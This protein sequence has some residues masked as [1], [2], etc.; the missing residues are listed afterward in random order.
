MT[1]QQSNQGQVINF[2]K[3]KSKKPRKTGVNQNRGG[4][5]RNINGKAYVDF[6]YLG[7]RVRENS[8]LAWNTQNVKTVR[9]LLD[10][11]L[12]AI[13]SETF[14]YAEVFPNSNKRAYFAAKEKEAFRLPTTPDQVK[15]EE[16]FT[17]WYELLKNSG[18]VAERT[19]LGYKSIIRLYLQPYFGNMTFAQF[20]VNTFDRFTGWARKQQYRGKTPANETI[21]KCF[22]VLKM[23]CKSV[24]IEYGWKS[25]FEPFFGFRKLP[26][27]DP[28]EHIMPFS[29]EEQQ[30]LMEHLP[31]HWQPYFRFAFCSGLR[32]GEQ[33]GLKPGDIDWEKQTITISRAITLDENGHRVEGTTKNRYSRREI[34]LL[35]VMLEALLAQKEI[36]ERFNGEYFFC[37]PTGCQIHLG[38]LL[39]RVWEPALKK[40]GLVYREMKQ[41]RHSFATLTLSSGVNP[42]WIAKVL[43]HRNT[44]MIFKVYGKYI[45]KFNEQENLG[46]LND[47]FQVGLG[48]DD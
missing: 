7:E 47:I 43:G 14:R 29:L 48:K 28:Y 24:A 11:I 45:E 26:E 19:L 13:K 42:L 15:C 8:G 5:V 17:Q 44:E 23:I 40:A 20:N 38:N 41:T 12:V 46:F 31:E 2:P 32:V 16:F 6:I 27:G 10:K 4:S 3:A 18:R 35:P 21:N 22:T 34:K 9:E 33:L 37:S 36:Y 39:R 25:D 30:K 1:Q